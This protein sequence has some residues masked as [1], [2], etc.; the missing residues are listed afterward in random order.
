[1]TF[2]PVEPA[3]RSHGDFPRV[4][5]LPQEGVRAMSAAIAA[6]PPSMPL[7]NRPGTVGIVTYGPSD[8]S[9]D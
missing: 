5:I 2:V 6:A 1:M 9:V 8:A 4:M 3:P 7:S